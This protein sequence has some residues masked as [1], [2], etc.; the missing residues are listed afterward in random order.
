MS[1]LDSAYESFV[2][3]DRVTR[4]DG[5]GGYVS[6][7]TEGAEIEAA[8][9][10]DTSMQARTA[11]AQGVTSVYTIVT[12]RGVNLSYHDVLRRVETGK[13]FRVTS[14]GAD[15]KT[16]KGAGLDMREVTAEE[17]TLPEG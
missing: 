4:S 6:T 14:D 3:M 2:M 9:R 15:K 8:L 1:L 17:W 10:L 16:P 5:Y 11:E 12:K 7:W 13:V